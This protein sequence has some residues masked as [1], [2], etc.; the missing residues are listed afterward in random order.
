MVC[1][2]S[3]KN[4]VKIKIIDIIDKDEK[5]NYLQPKGKLIL[6]MYIIY[7]VPNIDVLF[8]DW[9]RNSIRLLPKTEKARKHFLR[10]ER[11]PINSP[12]NS[13]GSEYSNISLDTVHLKAKMIAKILMCPCF[14]ESFHE[15]GNN[16]VK[17]RN[18]IIL[19][20]N[21]KMIRNISF[22][23]ASIIFTLVKFYMECNQIAAVKISHSF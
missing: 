4:K 14:V 2:S 7:N 1:V 11:A 21:V 3:K 17:K 16:Y 15:E 13:S 18:R 20:A 12:P 6:R 22:T 9:Y 8:D 10:I 5:F 19:F 23:P